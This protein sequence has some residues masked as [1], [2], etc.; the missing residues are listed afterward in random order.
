MKFS[1]KPVLLEECIQGLNIKS[2][3]VYVDGTLGGAGHSL[4]I[5]KRLDENGTLVGIDQDIEALE[6]AKFRLKEI[7]TKPKIEFGHTNFQNIDE[8]CKT[9]NISG[10]DGVLL[11]LGVS[12]HQ[13]D[14]ATR[15]FSYNHDSMLDMRMDIRQKMTAETVVNQYTK[16]ELKKVIW[17]Y[18]EEKWADRI[19]N[20]IV[21]YRQEKAIQTTGELAEIIKFAIPAKSRREGPHPAKRTFQAI[22]IEVNRE[23]DVLIE[24]INKIIPLLNPGGRICIITF[25]SLEDRIVKQKFMEEAK[26]CICPSGFP[27]CICQQIPTLKLISKK[28]IEPSDKELEENPRARSA[29]LRIAQKI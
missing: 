29:K 8:V 16:E 27:V 2:K 17:N 15:G 12:S 26:V 9:L 3:G 1:H 21:K 10:I 25:H 24:T 6:S 20:S 7:H 5:V 4:E 23:L 22:R 28:P 13:L 19:A 18:G 11:D 14:T